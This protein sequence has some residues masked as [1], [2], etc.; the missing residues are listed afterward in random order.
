MRKTLFTLLLGGAILLQ[1]C[2][3]NNETAIAPN[4][5][6]QKVQSYI[7]TV[8]AGKGEIL[9]KAIALDSDGTA[10][11]ATWKQGEKVTVFNKTKDANLEGYLEA[12][13]DGATTT[14][15]GKLTGTIEENDLLTLSFL[16]AEYANQD[17]TLEYIAANC[18]FA[19]A[20]VKVKSVAEG[21][22]TT[23][24]AAD[25]TNQQAIVE[26]TLKESNGNLITP[27]VS[28]L[29]VTAD[30][31]TITVTPSSAKNVLYVALPAISS[32]NLSLQ[33]VD[34]NG[35]PRSYTKA[36]AT[37][38]NGQFYKIGVKMKC[39]VTNDTE[40]FAANTSKVPEITLGEDITI[41]I[42]HD[43]VYIS[44]NATINMNGHSLSGY[45]IDGDPC[46]RVFYVDRGKSLT[47]NGPG[48]IKDVE[49]GH[50]GAIVNYG[51]LVIDGVTFTNC[52][53]ER[54]GAIYNR[55]TLT[56]NNVTFSGNSASISGGA[57]YNDGTLNISGTIVA[58]DNSVGNIYL[59]AGSVINV[60][61]ALGEGSSIGVT[62][63]GGS[64]TA[65]AGI[66]THNGAVAAETFF[67][68]DEASYYVITNNNGE[69]EL[70][71][72]ENLYSGFT[73]DLYRSD[74]LFGASSGWLRGDVVYLFFPGVTDGFIK[75]VLNDISHMKWDITPVGSTVAK[76]SM[77]TSSKV[78]AVYLPAGSDIAPTYGES[79]WTFDEAASGYYYLADEN[80]DVT[81]GSNG[82]PFI[83]AHLSAPRNSKRIALPTS[84]NPTRLACSGM[85][86]AHLAGIS[87]DASIIQNDD[88]GEWMPVS[89]EA[90][91][92]YAYGC[93]AGTETEMLYYALECQGDNYFNYLQSGMTFAQLAYPTY[94][95]E[96]TGWSQVGDGHYVSLGG[97]NWLTVNLVRTSYY[98]N[99]GEYAAYEA[100]KHP[101]T[102]AGVVPEDNWD[103]GLFSFQ[104]CGSDD[105]LKPYEYYNG[106]EH[107][108]S[109]TR[110]FPERKAPDR[111]QIR[112][113]RN[114]TDKYAIT[115]LGVEG[116]LVVDKNNA[117][118]YLFLPD[119]IYWSNDCLAYDTDP[120]YNNTPSVI[121][122]N[123]YLMKV[124]RG[125]INPPGEGYEEGFFRG[126]TAERQ[127]SGGVSF[128]HVN[129]HSYR[130]IQ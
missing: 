105:A 48:T 28:S 67:T 122:A 91:G 56:L 117:S 82:C 20:E 15:K 78:T 80:V 128:W 86:P 17:G 6:A 21:N 111:L 29:I 76:K 100:C 70:V 7:M 79:G 115:M 11:N 9:T 92:A 81:T 123:V 130:P 98:Y 112:D 1:G 114:A 85:R 54:G 71:E 110:T 125:D 113:L 90:E 72:I 4:E 22:I 61:G 60:A 52:K 62:L 59:A 96:N 39:I 8:V 43:Y 69:A 37:F 77:V 24:A 40:L 102:T 94:H 99:T 64:G 74:K 3:K 83:E 121:Y 89:T 106:G 84:G 66:S 5:Q 95:L 73:V 87:A 46:D 129:C 97:Q 23:F 44:G 55:A 34:P 88:F 27:G 30:G 116:T 31:T 41:T 120:W 108:V 18:D 63:A 127:M 107:R 35:A 103:L 118:R 38:N 13:A 75:A 25:F 12:Q 36:A 32:G 119:G 16:D 68:A 47:L 51:V 49:Q 104:D 14:L 2:V 33:A 109:L 58:S 101:W 50:G 26:F 19:T 53:A 57:I 124:V 65:T 10:L 126:D 93:L 42:S 45:S